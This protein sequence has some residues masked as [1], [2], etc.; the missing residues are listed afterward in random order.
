M[1]QVVS[2]RRCW[3]PGAVGGGWQGYCRR[4]RRRGGEGDG[5]GLAAI[6]RLAG[7]LVALIDP[8]AD[9]PV[10]LV[11]TSFGGALRSR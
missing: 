10:I 8:I 3:W 5:G 7:R 9:P 11:G 4:R 2:E 1:R 6:R